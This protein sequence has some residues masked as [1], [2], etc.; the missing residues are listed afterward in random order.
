MAVTAT[1]LRTVN[2]GEL[3]G[4]LYQFTGDGSVK[5]VDLGINKNIICA[6]LVGCSA[7]PV[8]CELNVSDGSTAAA[9]NIYWDTALGSSATANYIVLW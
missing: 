9:G 7:D 8:M 2:M 4:A 5:Y 1:R 6:I 3:N